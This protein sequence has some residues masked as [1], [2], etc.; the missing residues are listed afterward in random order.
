MKRNLESKFSKFDMLLIAA[1]LVVL[2]INIAVSG[3]LPDPGMR[4]ASRDAVTVTGTGAG[5]V[6]D[7]VVEVTADKSNIY[8]VKILDQN[9]T[10]GIGSLAVEQLPAAIVGANSVAVDSVASATVTSDAIKA[11]VCAAL[12]E[13]GYNPADFGYVEPTPAPTPEPTPLPTPAA[14][15][16]AGGAQTAQGSGTGIDGKIV[17]EVKADANTIY[18]VNILEQNETPGIGSVAVEKLPAAI[19][20]ANSLEVDGVTGA[21]VSSD[22]IKAAVSE[23]LT[24]MGFDPAS[25]QGAAVASA[26]PAGGAQTAQGSGTGIDG[27]IVVEVKADAN[28]IYEVNIL[29]QN[30]TPGI[31]SVAVEKL[32]AAIVEANSL[33]VDGV[34]G[35]TV[36]SSAIKAAVSEALT[37]MGFDPASYQGAAVA[38]APAEPAAAGSGAMKVQTMSGVT[39]M[40]AADWK[41]QFP[42]QY[43]SFMMTKES[44]EAEDY[45]EIYPM[46]RGLYEGYGFAKDYKAARGHYYDVQ[47]IEATGRPHPLANCWTCKTPDFTNMVN[48]EGIS[49]YQKDWTEVQAQITEG[50]SCYTCHANTP[51]PITATH[52]YWIDAVG[53]DFDR[54]AP[55]NLACGQ[56]HNEYY[57]APDTKATTIAHNSLES[58]AP[59]TMLAF[60]NDGANFPNG[61]PFAD[62]TNPRTGVRQIKVQHPEFETFLGAGSPHAG[63]FT[64]ADCHMPTAT[65]ADGTTYHS[66]NLISPL[67]NQELLDNSCSLCHADLRSEVKALQQ[68]VE[69]RTYEVGYELEYLTELLAQAVESGAYTDEQLA[70]IRQLARDSQFYWDFVF[71]ENAEGAHNPALTYDCLDRADALCAE[72]TGLLL[73]LTR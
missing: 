48:E 15:A 68:K 72:A 8:S 30:E 17:V 69:T 60:F 73:A 33:E 14:A 29:E 22:A 43:E 31:G 62:W 4:M 39:V 11:A 23:A 25:Y 32:P 67:D 24:A 5:K 70:R 50:I 34:T 36:S 57:F 12:S 38:A 26:A 16:P 1:L 28:T 35:A 47:D 9:E 55:A 66:H 3:R 40:H 2:V 59:E 44:S 58:M 13:A 10:P 20:E 63:T 6:G 18:E 65:A 56:C 7:V 71:V 61:E 54:I 41:E 49:A 51:G 42:D 45:L 21:T 64:C 46:L 53:D 52:T 37:A 27:K 19:V